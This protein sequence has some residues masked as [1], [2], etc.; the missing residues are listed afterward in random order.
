MQ[1]NVQPGDTFNSI[2]SA[3]TIGG[4]AYGPAIASANDY[5]DG[6][7]LNDGTMVSSASTP[8]NS[9]RDVITIDDSWLKTSGTAQVPSLSPT[10]LLLLAGLAFFLFNG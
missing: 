5:P 4:S 6:T 2:A 1:Y 3:L 7:V 8:V 9:L 10:T